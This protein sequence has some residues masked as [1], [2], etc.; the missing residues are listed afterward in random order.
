MIF[1]ALSFFTAYSRLI[2][3]HDFHSFVI[4]EG[5]LQLIFYEE[6]MLDCMLNNIKRHMTS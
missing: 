4:F 6:E 3:C 5:Y 2:F 1:T